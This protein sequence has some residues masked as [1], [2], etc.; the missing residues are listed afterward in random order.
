MRNRYLFLLHLPFLGALLFMA[1]NYNSVGGHG[2]TLMHYFLVEQAGRQPIYFFD[3]WGKPFFT[4]FAFP[5]AQFG[6]VGIKIFNALC[7]TGAVFLSTLAAKKLNRKH[8]W[9]IPVLAFIAPAFPFYLMSGLTE[10]FS[11]LVLIGSVVLLLYKKP[12]PA[13]I[14]AS[15]LPFCRSEAQIL[16]VIFLI[17][18]LLQKHYRYLPLLLAGTVIYALVGSYWHG[19]VFWINEEVYRAGPSAY[20]QGTW[21]HF[22]DRLFIMTAL[23]GFVLLCLGLIWA[24]VKL[25]KTKAFRLKE[26]W[27]IHA[28]FLAIFMAHTTVWALGIYASAGLERVLILVFPMMWIIMLDGLNLSLRKLENKPA[29]KGGIISVWILLIVGF[30]YVDNRF[31]NHYFKVHTNLT[32]EQQLV[33]DSI[34]PYI[35]EHYP[36][37]D[38]FFTDESYLAIAT[39][40]NKKDAAHFSHWISPQ[41]MDTSSFDEH[42]L[43]LWDDKRVAVHHGVELKDLKEVAWLRE[44]KQWQPPH[45][46]MQFVL[47]DFNPSP[48][49]SDKPNSSSE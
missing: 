12:I 35:Q 34:Y 49:A 11:A 37:A 23:P 18:G 48:Q 15:F 6:F 3:L 25:F 17:Y 10:P 46:G 9:L 13:Y 40:Y 16:L 20:G 32:P 8:Y 14:L 38:F 7:G 22:V 43:F 47:F 44:I 26:M 24:A 39:G 4:L 31:T 41:D 29:Y 28:L 27:L 19:S 1:I 30:T 33:H 42:V 36:E 2:D 45:D 21:M 5:F